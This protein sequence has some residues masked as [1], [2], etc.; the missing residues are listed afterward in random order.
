MNIEKIYEP[1]DDFVVLRVICP[2]IK[3]KRVS[4]SVE[5]LV[6]GRINL[7]D[8]IERETREALNRLHNHET[9]ARMLE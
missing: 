5:A 3:E 4:I 1:G 8:E 6:D 2:P 7:E 9:V